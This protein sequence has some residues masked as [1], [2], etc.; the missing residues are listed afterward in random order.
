MAGQNALWV[1]KQHGHSIL[2]MLT[3]YVAWVQ[4]AA[5]VDIAAIRRSLLHRPQPIRVTI[6]STR[7]RPAESDLAVD[8]A[9][10]PGP[11]VTRAWKTSKKIGGADGTR[12]TAV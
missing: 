9:V 10:P 11:G 12:K 6:R 2:T 7:S 4:G 3:V 1:A 5:P 8:L